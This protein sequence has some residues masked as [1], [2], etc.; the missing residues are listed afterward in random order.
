MKLNTRYLAGAALVILA[1]IGGL[2]LANQPSSAASS[3]RCSRHGQPYQVVIEN[4]H[5]SPEIT[6]AK[7]CGKLEFINQDN[8]IREIAFGPHE[9]H[10]AYDGV[11]ARVL[12]KGQSF[13]ITLNQIG[14]FH[15]HDHIH[16]E[17]SGFFNVTK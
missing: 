12:G 16:D 15:F 9:R 11:A 14:L 10:V 17:V 13:T 1:L 2:V 8:T 5:A 6:N 4:D 3:S 7:L